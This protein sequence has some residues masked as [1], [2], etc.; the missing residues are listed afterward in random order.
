MKWHSLALFETRF[1]SNLAALESRDPVLA[2]RLRSVRV[3]APC[4]IAAVGDE[5]FLGRE[6][7]WGIE[8]VPNT[9]S[10]PRAREIIA[11]VFPKSV[12]T[13]PIVV[14]GLAYGWSWDRIFKLPC[15]VDT[16]PGHRPPIYLLTGDIER[17]WAVLH[18]MDWG[19]LLA[20]PRMI[21][22]AGPDAA[23]QL[24]TALVENPTWPRPR[25]AL[26]IERQLLNRDLNA[27]LQD[28][29]SASQRQLAHLY[30]RL[31][32]IYAMIT[33]QQW[34]KKFEAG[35][36]LR[37]LG[38]TSRYTTFLQHSMRD[39]LAAFGRL[40]HQTQLMIE[41]SDHILLG[42]SGYAQSIL[43]FKPDLIL[44]I[45]HF[46]AELGRL[47]ESVPCVMYVQD[48][49][50]NMYCA[51]AGAAQGTRDYCIGLGRLHLTERYGYPP[52]RFVPATV[53]INDEKFTLAPISNDQMRRFG[54]DVS[55]VSHS[56][57][58]AD[59]LVRNQLD[60]TP[61]SPV[62]TLVWD[63]YEQM[64]AH[65]EGGGEVLAEPVLRRHLTQT[66]DRLGVALGDSQHADILYL[67]A[68]Q[69]NNSLFRHQALR[70]IAD[71]GVDLRLYGR[72]W[73]KHPQLAR[74]ARGE[75]DNACDLPAI[76]R[77]S[78]INLQLIPFGAV[79]QR[80]L[81]GL[82]AGGFFLMRYTPGDALGVP[83]M[84]LWDW[85]LR[86][87]I[88]GDEQMRAAADDGAN[89]LIAEIDQMQDYDTRTVPL[90]L[91]DCI[92]STAD[93][94]FSRLA[95]SMWPELYPKL[96]F[97]NAA[98]LQTQ[99][100]QYLANDQLRQQ[101]VAHMRQGVMDRSSYRSITQRL[102]QH[103]AQCLG[104]EAESAANTA[105]QAA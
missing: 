102:L 51:A 12:A 33:P 14:G 50:P 101:T 62:A 97:R 94:G 80:L 13:F 39:W 77:A 42:A 96:S 73:E 40:G 68:Q 49:L 21:I 70:W 44:V 30:G 65:F 45:D 60:N 69:V 79:H 2:R 46:R 67:L 57:T 43:D 7:A 52:E 29:E 6:T 23:A 66:Q 87:Q 82:A 20:D 11:G 17:L 35:S 81:D 10:A 31:E 41:P 24:E 34:A 56:S 86:N 85:C 3:S 19:Q 83:Y 32:S 16:A 18:F 64:A 84:K 105:R 5:V 98:Q 27:I 78:K 88:T 90:K 74:Y 54:C 37:V 75:A 72:G 100:S 89:A 103:I 99:L 61:N 48:R 38:I 1:A 55:Y 25:L 95:G 22:F 28:V 9:L 63:L 8:C 53:G 4:Y 76:Y 58:P 71:S 104:A 26:C 92:A 47:P 15:Q 59:V 91:Y 36:Q 93:E